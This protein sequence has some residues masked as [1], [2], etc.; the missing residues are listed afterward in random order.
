METVGDALAERA[1]NEGGHGTGE[2][3][4]A[5]R[6]MSN[7]KTPNAG[8]GGKHPIVTLPVLVESPPACLKR[9]GVENNALPVVE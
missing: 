4:K 3:T 2:K 6:L 5:G 8:L 7:G 1:M 9:G